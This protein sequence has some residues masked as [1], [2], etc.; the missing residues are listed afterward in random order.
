MSA[1][2]IGILAL[3]LGTPFGLA[4]YSDFVA[5]SPGGGRVAD[6][7]QDQVDELQDQVDTARA[8]AE[9][10]ARALTAQTQL[11]AQLGDHPSVVRAAALA[12]ID[13]VS[14]TDGL[15]VDG[16]G[17]YDAGT[18]VELADPDGNLRASLTARWGD[19]IARTD[20]FEQQRWFWFD[21]ANAVRVMLVEGGLD[22]RSALELRPYTPLGA[23]VHEVTGD[24]GK[25]ASALPVADASAT[26]AEMVRP[27][28]EYSDAATRVQL[29]SEH[30]TVTRAVIFA[31]ILYNP[32]F[33]FEL[34][35]QLSDGRGQPTVGPTDDG[36]TRYD[37]PGRPPL[38]I[39]VAGEGDAMTIQLGHLEPTRP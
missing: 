38:R 29:W 9:A 3:V 34:A 36:G 19:P 27:P 16:K 18:F 12:G 23:L 8:E 17:K 13:G 14:V 37:F 30:G 22:D 5:P 20:S 25:P 28:S 26:P 2:K 35:K 21:Q 7:L 24:L 33:A 4:V 10:H 31:D 1:A 39:D 32:G 15:M 11:L 6:Q